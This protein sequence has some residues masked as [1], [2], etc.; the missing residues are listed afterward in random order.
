[1][2][3]L[4]LAILILVFYA[5]RIWQFTK[6]WDA[7]AAYT[8]PISEKVSLLIASRNEEKNIQSLV[9]SL[10]NQT[11]KIEEIIVVDDHSTDQT[12]ALLSSYP[13]I[14]VL[15]S[16]GEGKKAAIA[17]AIAQ[18]Q[19]PIILTTDADCEMG[20]QWVEKMLQPFAD[21]SVDLVVG[22]VAFTGEKN[23]FEKS[24]S[25]EFMSLI[26]SGA[27]AIGAE[28][29]FMCNGANLAYRKAIYAD[30]DNDKASGDDVF[31]L[32]HVK[33]EGGKIAFVKEEKAIV[34]T[35]PKKTL[36]ELIQ[37]RQ[38]WAAKS[39]SYKDKEA[40]Q[41]SYLVFLANLA[42]L[43]SYFQADY[44]PAMLL[45]LIKSVVDYPL[46]RK[47]SRFMKKEAY[48]P[49]FIPLQL[50]YPFYIVYVAVA[51]QFGKF[52]WKGRKHKR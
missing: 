50:V 1:M 27:G 23:I 43:C 44:R 7:L 12:V 35:H 19:H 3:F 40:T 16:E 8:E 9:T 46:L 52:K 34:Y 11:H 31:L 29:A 30:V 10:T 45:L 41:T 6:G 38:R 22:P 36:S 24:Q 14:R 32:H 4:L 5:I 49:L 33:K 20:E 15:Q 13:S 48:M 42:L 21:E 18:A 17:Q 25:L 37:Q 47:M 51:S 39:T 26:A 2:I 28:R